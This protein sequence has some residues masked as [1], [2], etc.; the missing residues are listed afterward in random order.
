M[1]AVIVV[2]LLGG[3]SRFNP[4]SFGQS[5]TIDWVDFVKLHGKSYTGTF[6]SVIGDAAAVTPQVVGEV[7]F[8]VAEVVTNPSY[9]TK[10]GDAAFLDIGTKLYRV[11]GFDAK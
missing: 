10:D 5:S 11:D 8:K 2:M 3:C 1:I 7:S 9:R 4:D 6:Q